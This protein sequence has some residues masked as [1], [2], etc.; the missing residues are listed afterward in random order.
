MSKPNGLECKAESKSPSINNKT[1]LVEPHEGQ[2]I[3]VDILIG[4]TIC[5]A[6]CRNIEL[7]I[8]Q[9]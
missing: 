8:I 9:V 1:D 7:T 4:Q 3:P 5:F 6:P 2:G